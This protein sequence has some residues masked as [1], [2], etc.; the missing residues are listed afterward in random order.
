M[1]ELTWDFSLQAQCQAREAAGQ[2]SSISG[3]VFFAGAAGTFCCF[4]LFFLAMV[5]WKGAER[6]QPTAELKRPG[7]IKSSLIKTPGGRRRSSVETPVE[8]IA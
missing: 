3:I 8:L 5:A 7:G 4:S 6:R 2:P 1:T